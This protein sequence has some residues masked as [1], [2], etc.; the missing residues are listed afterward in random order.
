MSEVILD[1]ENFRT[2]LALIRKHVSCPLFVVLGKSEDVEISNMN[3]A[4]FLYLMK[5]ELPETAILISNTEVLAVT[6]PKKAVILGQLGSDLRVFVRN[7]DNSNVNE[8]KEQI[9][10][11]GGKNLG[12]VDRENTKGAFCE[13]IME[14]FAFNDLT[15]EIFRL[16]QVK[17]DAEVEGATK[18]GKSSGFFMQKC[19]EFIVQ[20]QAD[21]KRT[22]HGEFS[23]RLEDILYEEGNVLEGLQDKLEFTFPPFLQS[24]NIFDL[25]NLYFNTVEGTYIKYD[26]VLCKVGMRYDGYCAELAR[27]LVFNPEQ[28]L[29]D[30][31]NLVYEIHRTIV[32]F[33][34]VGVA[35]GLVKIKISDL[36]REKNV[37]ERINDNV[38][39]STGLCHREALVVEK[40][41]RGMIVVVNVELKSGLKV[42][43]LADT[44]HVADKLVR[45]TEDTHREVTGKGTDDHK[46]AL[47]VGNSQPIVMRTDKKTIGIRVRKRDQDLE[48]NIRRAEHQKELLDKLIED[49][50]AYYK[51]TKVDEKEKTEEEKVYIPYKKE[52]LVLRKPRLAVDKKSEAIMIPIFDYCVP[53]H[54]SMV[55]NM[56]KTEESDHAVIRI[57]FNQRESQKS[58]G[59]SKG[60]DIVRSI[61][62]TGTPHFID[63]VFEQISELKKSFQEKV[64]LTIQNQDIVEQEALRETKGR[65]IVLH[66]VTIRTD[67]KTGVRK[68]V[69]GNLELHENGVRFSS[70]SVEVLFSNVKHIF[71][72]EATIEQ[73]AILH[74][75]LLNPLVIGKKT[76]N[77]QF[78]KEVGMNTA[79]DTIK[80][81]NDE[82]MEMV[83]DKEFEDK[84][85]AIN[86]EFKA[87]IE[88]I[89]ES[90]A[91][92]VEVPY[93]DKGFYGV[94]F[95]E[96]VMIHPTNEC[97]VSL[98]DS[99]FL[100]VTLSEIEIV[101]FERVVYGVKTSDLVI[102]MRDKKRPPFSVLSVDIA[103]ISD[104]K[105]FFDSK[106]VIF[107]ETKVNIQWS[108]LIK[109]IMMDPLSFYENNAWYDL[110]NPDAEDEESESVTDV[111][112]EYT[113]S[114][115]EFDTEDESDASEE[116]EGED[117]VSDEEEF[118]ESEDDDGFDES[119]EDYDYARKRKK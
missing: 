110:I 36:M 41:E 27:T 23:Q 85:C 107:L 94:P 92:K 29:L 53:F 5:Y 73:R 90:H 17:T 98:V 51:N 114:E 31:L 34:R 38:I 76:I 113:S 32:D 83:L 78:C 103:C 112:T 56:S 109:T 72:Q 64:N 67:N 8:I 108:N 117:E 99:P 115:E 96:S 46:C 6:S 66:D 43:G 71:Y 45:I 57:N 93:V 61:S 102:V 55:K 18:A 15:N 69:T 62:Y 44:F 80:N 4:I 82:Y 24:G 75:H 68:A 60:L 48:K 12:V 1:K 47:D 105:D 111:D 84:R 106:G 70:Q 54:V 74:M 42:L 52:V 39:Y 16:F 35:V 13:M 88:H 95:R 59:T 2:R 19:A 63:E 30:D 91:I 100:V 81:K 14:G 104:L 28:E 116:F 26:N 37:E 101:N 9:R 77:V 87:F 97:L 10:K 49:M 79:H 25:G 3:S 21:M 33:V 58:A 20:D 7:K 119:S 50:K 11:V 65:R 40:F 22:T 89:E 86:K 118:Y